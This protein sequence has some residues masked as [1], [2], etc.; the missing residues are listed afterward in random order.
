MK[1]DIKIT[2]KL[3]DSINELLEV[4]LP[5]I[6]G[7]NLERIKKLLENPFLDVF[8]LEIDGRVAG[9]VSLHYMETLVKKSAWVEDVVVHPKHQGKGLGK[10]MMKHVIREAGKKGVKHLDLT[11][12]SKRVAANSLY[13]KLKFEPRETNV[14]RLK[15]KKKSKNAR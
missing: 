12:N 13:Q 9:M 1:S 14:Y 4:L 5:G 10:K 15:V 7:I 3:I 6:E 2:G 8:I 11:S